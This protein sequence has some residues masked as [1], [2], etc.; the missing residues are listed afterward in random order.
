MQR[1][2]GSFFLYVLLSDRPK[3]AKHSQQQLQDR[4]RKANVLLS[5]VYLMKKVRKNCTDIPAKIVFLCLC[6]PVAI[7]QLLLLRSW[8]TFG[9]TFTK[10]VCD[11][12]LLEF[13]HTYVSYV[14]A[15]GELFLVFLLV[16]L[17][18]LGFRI[19]ASYAKII[20]ISMRQPKTRI[21]AI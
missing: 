19:H 21:Y 12:A 18:Q 11:K 10:S 16:I 5:W 17:G 1:V 3:I 2:P 7:L 6:L 14:W 15:F 8:A 9:P 13:V 20:K 4:T